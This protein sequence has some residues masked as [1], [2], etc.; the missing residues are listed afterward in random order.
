MMAEQSSVCLPVEP[1][2]TTKSSEV[3]SRRQSIGMVCSGNKK[4]KVIPHYLRASTGSCH[5]LCKYG[6]KHAFEAIEKRS[7]LISKDCCPEPF[8]ALTSHLIMAEQSVDSPMASETT[9]SSGVELRR[10]STGKAIS[11]NNIEKVIPHYL[12]A[13]TGSCHEFCK[14]GKKHEFEAIEKCSVSKE[15]VVDSKPTKISVFECRKSIETKSSNTNK[16]DLQ[17]KSSDIKRQIGNEVLSNGNKTSLVKVKPSTFSKPHFSTTFKV[18]TQSKSSSKK[19][20]N[21]S[22]SISKKKE[23]LQKSTSNK[24]ETPSKS[25]SKT[26][27]TPAKSTFNNKKESPSKSTSGR[28]KTHSKSTPNKM[29]SSSKLSSLKGKEM[30]F[31]DEKRVISL[32]QSKDIRSK[33]NSEIKKEKREVTCKVDSPS[34]ASLKSKP[35]HKRSASFNA[36]MHKSLKIVSYVN[37]QPK[38]ELVEPKEHNHEVEEKTLHVIKVENEN[39]TLQSDQNVCQDI[40]LSLSSSSSSNIQSSSKEDQEESEYATTNELVEEDS[41]SGNCEID[42]YIE[43]DTQTEKSNSRRRFKF[44]LGRVLGDNA[45]KAKDGADSND[46]PEIVFLRHLDVQRKKDGRRLFNTVIEE[47]ASKLVKSRKSKV[48]ALVGAFETVISLQEKN[49]FANIH[50]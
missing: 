2:E 14:Y 43:N 47:T 13:S 21:P 20:K 23:T 28:V 17:T 34:T 30:E 37:K 36:R 48:K 31:S 6:R 15:A 8:S 45:T 5:D 12:M 9:N 18:E 50:C 38:H 25:T 26:K 7:T 33:R 46:G 29:E 49:P 39:Q 40:K 44:R 24:K 11:R 16:P 22:K 3:E 42:E 10:H 32:M 1:E 27:E 4:E 35:S 19:K 41:F